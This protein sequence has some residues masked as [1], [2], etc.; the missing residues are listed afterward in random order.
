MDNEAPRR[1]RLCIQSN[2][3][4][5]MRMMS[6]IAIAALA[7]CASANG[8]TERPT[9]TTRIVGATGGTSTLSMSSNTS[10]SVT[11][12]AFPIDRVWR[13]MPSV[14]DS[15]GIHLTVADQP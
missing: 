7:A 5:C 6:V 12:I 10:A 1:H 11:T 8:A 3:E 2:G 4:L 13:L 15:L 14:Y 9:E